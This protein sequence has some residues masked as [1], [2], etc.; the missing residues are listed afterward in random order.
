M[1]DYPPNIN[2]SYKPESAAQ[3]AKNKKGIKKLLAR[4]GNEVC[5]DC[6]SK[7]PRWASINLGIFVCVPC[8]AVHRRIGTHISKVKSTNLDEWNS[9]WIEHVKTWGNANA[10]AYWE[11]DMPDRERKPERNATEREKFIR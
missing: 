9:D 8:S 3:Q 4:A 7:A 5:A 2:V 6:P 10:N 11:A 1:C